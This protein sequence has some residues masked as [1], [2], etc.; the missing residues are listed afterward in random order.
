MK[1]IEQLREERKNKADAMQALYDAA[2]AESRTALNEAESTAFDALDVELKAIDA[3]LEKR[4]KDESRAARL[5]QVTAGT[6]AIIT[7]LGDKNTP[8]KFSLQRA[9][10]IQLNNAPFDGVEKE[11]HDE[12]VVQNLRAGVGSSPK[13]IIIP[14]EV[15]RSWKPEL[16]KRDM[17]AGTAAAGGYFVQTDVMLNDFIDVLRDRL[18]IASAGAQTWGGLVGNVNVPSNGGVTMEWAAT[19]NAQ[20]TGSTPTI[21]QKQ[22][23][24]HRTTG[25]TNISG[26]LLQQT[27]GFVE[28]M[29][30]NDYMNANAVLIQA[31][32]IN[33]S[34]SS[35]QPTGILNTSGIGN[36]VG[37]TNGAAPDYQDIIDLIKEVAVDNADMGALAFITNPKVQA[38]LSA[39]NLDSGSGQFVWDWRN[40]QTPLVGNRAFVTNGAPSTLTKGTASGICSAIVYG[41]WNDLIIGGWGLPEFIIDP[42]TS[43]DYDLVRM[44]IHNHVDI[45]VRRAQSFSAML[46]ALAA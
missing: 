14:I 35:G 36:V 26:R 34:G 27:G 32:A 39:T 28:R 44:V 9:M 46:D 25:K 21:A 13:G 6:P 33:G 30:R 10:N 29:L 43:A 20:A 8:Q 19:E 16:E 5:A 31:A 11:M 4:T 24:P 22:L 41:N 17:S 3:E 12:G 45:L 15:Y 42:Y 23:T 2:K 37:G 7:D 40:P 18:V 1:T 38:V